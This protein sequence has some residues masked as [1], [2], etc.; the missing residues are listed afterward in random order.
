M[1]E[2]RRTTVTAARDDLDT[3]QAEAQRRDVPLTA[4]VAEAIAE[5]AA[6]LRTLNRPRLGVAHS[7]DGRSAAEVTAEPVAHP[8]R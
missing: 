2:P 8:P 1:A 5:K 3:L 6:S 4:V 7:A